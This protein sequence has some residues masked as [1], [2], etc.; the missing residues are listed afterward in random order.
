MIFWKDHKDKENKS[1]DNDGS[2]QDGWLA[3]QMLVSTPLVQGGCFQHSVVFMCEHSETGAMGFIINKELRVA[4]KRDLF[5]KLNLEYEELAHMPV[6]LGGPVET[7]RGFVVH[8]ADYK[9]KNTIEFEGGLAITSEKQVMQDYAKGRGPKNI[10]LVMGYSGW[11]G[12]QLEQE[13]AENSWLT[14]PS[15]PQ[16]IFN[17]N[18]D[19][20][21]QLAAAQNGIDVYKISPFTGS[22]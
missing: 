16:I 15:D 2:T 13:F 11:V 20:K 9:I 21:W 8:S 4:D 10:M 1:P 6:L 22:A 18:H 5:E 3:G 12:G 17:E 19:S 7:S 14:I